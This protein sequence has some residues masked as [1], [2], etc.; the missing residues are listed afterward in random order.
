MSRDRGYDPRDLQRCVVPQVADILVRQA[1][2]SAWRR[3]NEG[4]ALPIAKG[5]P[6]GCAAAPPALMFPLREATCSREP[7]GFGTPE[8]LVTVRVAPAAKPRLALLESR[9]PRL[10]LPSAVERD[11]RG[12]A[13]LG[14]RFERTATNTAKEPLPLGPETEVLDART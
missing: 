13:R 1:L 5:T 12:W 3:P 4:A 10:S 7:V 6:G 9:E 11:E 14:R 2:R 8:Y